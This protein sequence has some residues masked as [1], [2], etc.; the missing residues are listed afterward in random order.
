VAATDGRGFVVA[1]S[2]VIA[3]TRNGKQVLNVSGD[4]E[5][6]V[7]APVAEGADTVAV[8]G[9]NRKLLIFPL[10]ELPVMAR[11]RGVI[12]QKY[13]EGGL[14]DVR[15]FTFTKGFTWKSGRGTRTETELG[16]WVGKRAAIGHLPPRG[17]PKANCF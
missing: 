6:K 2:D 17:F 9:D 5:A 15:V 4:V 8:I 13:K 14:S 3:Q 16:T 12:L 11:G 7:C 1:E 10:G